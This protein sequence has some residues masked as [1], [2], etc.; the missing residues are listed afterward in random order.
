[1]MIR[2]K[3]VEA[4]ARDL[5]READIWRPPVPLVE[6]P[7][8]AVE[9]RRDVPMVA[10]MR[11]IFDQA[12]RAISLASLPTRSE[13]FAFAHELGHELLTTATLAACYTTSW[14]L[15]LPPQQQH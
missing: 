14:D 3:F 11:A 5:L 1:M 8:D 6:V 12:T 15:T 13:R 2:A 9:V 10:R 7:R 4:E